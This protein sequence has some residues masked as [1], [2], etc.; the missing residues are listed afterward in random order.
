MVDRPLKKIKFKDNLL[1][2][3]IGR[4]NNL[5]FPTGEDMLEVNDKIIIATTKKGIKGLNDILR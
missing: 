1:V 3:C 2:I 4:D 5:T